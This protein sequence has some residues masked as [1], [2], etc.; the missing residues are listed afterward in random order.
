MADH[1]LDRLLRIF[2]PVVEALEKLVPG[3]AIRA[4]Y[5]RDYDRAARRAADAL[6]DGEAEYEVL[7]PH[8]YVEAFA[9]HMDWLGW[10]VPAILTELWAHEPRPA[11]G[12]G[13]GGR[14][15]CRHDDAPW[16]DFPD[17]QGWCDHVAPKIAARIGCDPARAAEAL[18]RY[19]PAKVD[20]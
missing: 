20:L 1:P 13:N 16:S 19:K 14:I 2:A 8:P 10:A 5:D 3:Q 11:R 18:L 6:A 4:A 9:D 15:I 7:E 12:A 17:Y